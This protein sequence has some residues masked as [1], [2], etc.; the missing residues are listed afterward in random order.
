MQ[1]QPAPPPE[2]FEGAYGK[3]TQETS[4]VIAMVDMLVQDIDKEMT[5]AEVSEKDA[6]KDYETARQRSPSP[7]RTTRWL[8]EFDSAGILP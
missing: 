1:G 7:G 6:Q 8:V 3:K 5:E 2:T 4:G